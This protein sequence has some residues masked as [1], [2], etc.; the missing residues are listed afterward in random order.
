MSACPFGKCSHEELARRSRIWRPC[1]CCW[2]ECCVCVCGCW[3]RHLLSVRI[4][5]CAWQCVYC[6]VAFSH[7]WSS[8]SASL[9]AGSIQGNSSKQDQGGQ[10][11]Q[12]LN[13][14]YLVSLNK[15]LPHLPLSCQI[16]KC[17]GTQCS[18]MCEYLCRVTCSPT[19]LSSSVFMLSLLDLST[20]LQDLAHFCISTPSTPHSGRACVKHGDGPCTPGHLCSTAPEC[21]ALPGPRAL[22]IGGYSHLCNI[23][24]GK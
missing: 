9:L 4:G 23:Y 20:S 14:P 15:V 2:Y 21:Y 11:P 3:Q 16:Y 13:P 8:H 5:M 22:R 10:I 24:A 6:L 17:Y 1:C 18:V 19:G 7:F 12:I